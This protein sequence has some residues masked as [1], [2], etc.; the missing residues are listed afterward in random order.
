MLVWQ[1]KMGVVCLEEINDTSTN[2]YIAEYL[3]AVEVKAI[4]NFKQKF[5]C[6]V[7]SFVTDNTTTN[8]S[9]D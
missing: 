5:K 8:C 3:A 1:K 7:H 9:K 6:E 2:A 4:T